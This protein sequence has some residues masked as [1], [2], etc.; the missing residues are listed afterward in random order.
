MPLALSSVHVDLHNPACLFQLQF[1]L[2]VMNTNRSK[3]SCDAT[4]C[5]AATAVSIRFAATVDDMQHHMFCSCQSMF[6]VNIA[7]S[8]QL[9]F[10]IADGMAMMPAQDPKMLH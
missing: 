8:Q 6:D 4:V 10:C 2:L 3:F 5:D 9:A 1:S 7:V